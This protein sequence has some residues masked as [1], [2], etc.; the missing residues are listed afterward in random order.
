MV[1]TRLYLI[2]IFSIT[3]LTLE[4]SP[5]CEHWVA[6]LIS[7]TGKVEKLTK[8]QARWQPVSPDDCF[9]HGDKIRTARHGRARLK[10]II[11]PTTTVELEPN[12]TLTFPTKIIQH[13]LQLHLI[14]KYLLWLTTVISS[15]ITNKSLT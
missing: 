15:P 11:E 2:F 3:P 14:Q 6:R 10:F 7:T 5:E 4:A 8:N 12:S 13:D 1:H 9:C